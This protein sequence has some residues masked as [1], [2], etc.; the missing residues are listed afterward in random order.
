MCIFL[1]VS[2]SPNE[3]MS[4]PV[5]QIASA[6]Q[7]SS[8]PVLADAWQ[9]GQRWED[10]ITCQVRPQLVVSVLSKKANKY[11]STGTFVEQYFI[12]MFTF[13]V[14]VC[15]VLVGFVRLV[16]QTGCTHVTVNKYSFRAGGFV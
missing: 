14:A 10:N 1:Y 9:N 13:I 2:T 16:P 4:V 3:C 5:Q 11:F 6:G 8:E 15:L 12:D 7:E